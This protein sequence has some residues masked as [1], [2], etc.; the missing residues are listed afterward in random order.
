VLLKS[1]GCLLLAVYLLVGRNYYL[2]S[3]ATHKVY[4]VVGFLLLAASVLFLA[5]KFRGGD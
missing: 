3:S 4:T 2:P 1:V 5:A